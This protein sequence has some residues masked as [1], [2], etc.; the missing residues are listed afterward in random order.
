MA[1]ANKHVFSLNSPYKYPDFSQT[2]KPGKYCKPP[3]YKKNDNLD[4]TPR[5]AVDP[6]N[7]GSYMSSRSEVYSIGTTNLETPQHAFD[8]NGPRKSSDKSLSASSQLAK[9]VKKFR[10]GP[11]MSDSRV[12]KSQPQAMSQRTKAHLDRLNATS[13][14]VIPSK[15]PRG[16]V[17]P[18]NPSKAKDQ[19]NLPFVCP[20]CKSRYG[21]PDHVRSHFPSC[22]EQYGNPEGVKWSDGKKSL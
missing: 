18:P 5:F 2:Y 22:I 13:G 20:R 1:N 17:P 3:Y 4:S 21:R 10:T 8:A 16:Q 19:T 9:H 11:S 12:A 14:I 6:Y 7:L 15:L